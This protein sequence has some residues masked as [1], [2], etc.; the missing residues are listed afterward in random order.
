MSEMLR[1]LRQGDDAFLLRDHDDRHVGSVRDRTVRFT[2]FASPLDA[3]AAVIGG[4]NALAAYLG[5]TTA[6]REARDAHPADSRDAAP[7]GD[8]P[9]R[10]PVRLAHDGTHE[11]VVLGGRRVARLITP[12]D[13]WREGD[14]AD[15]APTD[16]APTAR[17]NGGGE[18]AIEFVLPDRVST[19]A[20]LTLAQVLYSA[21]RVHRSCRRP[22]D[23]LRQRRP[24]GAGVAFARPSRVADATLP[25]AT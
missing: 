20:S 6:L 16:Q 11:W 21:V 9:L 24:S 13:T 10:R 12:L 5:G 22:D 8:D 19:D 23:G 7:D 2:G 4:G 14:A 17:E 1:I 18:F 25:P 3:V 15:D